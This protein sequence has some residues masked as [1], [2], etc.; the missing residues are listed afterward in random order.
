MHDPMTVAHEIKAPWKH[1]PSKLW[2]KGYRPTL[3]TIWHV[4]PERDGSD[5][6]CGWFK[7]ARHGDAT[8]LEKIR[9]DFAF[10]WD[11]DYGGWFDKTGKPILSPAGITLCM[12]RLAAAH[13]FRGNRWSRRTERFMRRYLFEILYFAENPTDSMHPSIVG[14]YGIEKREDRIA[15]A[16]S[17]IY[18]C[19]LRWD[20][21]WYRHPRW[22]FWHWRLQVHPWQALRRRLLTRCA[23]CGKPFIGECPTSF[24]WGSKPKRWF[25]GEEGLYHSKCAGLVVAKPAGNA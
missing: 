1:A 17:I 8:V 14:R 13:H 19:V 7:R 3:I 4:D 25:R 5:D 10:D 6:S 21:P 2:P 16:A 24:G 15:Q 20:Q 11:A 12:F 9:N 22:H 23:G 18:G